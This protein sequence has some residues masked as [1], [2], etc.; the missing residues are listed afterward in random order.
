MPIPPDSIDIPDDGS[1][2]WF[3]R[4]PWLLVFVL[5]VLVIIGLSTMLNFAFRTFPGSVE[6]EHKREPASPMS[7]PHD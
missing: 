5:F 7:T 1:G 2:N 6:L 4:R 3:T